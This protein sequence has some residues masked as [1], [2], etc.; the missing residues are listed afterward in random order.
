MIAY[1]LTLHQTAN[2]CRVLLSGELLVR[3]MKTV[4]RNNKQT[5]R[6]K[7]HS[8]NKEGKLALFIGA[9]ISVGCG[10][11]DWQQLMLSVA[12]SKWRT[13]PMLCD[14]VSKENQ[15]ISARY[16]KRKG[17]GKFNVLVSDCLYNNDIQISKELIAIAG[18]GIKKICNFNFDDLIEE[19]FLTEGIEAD[20]ILEGDFYDPLSEKVTI[21]HPHGFIERTGT[22][23]EIKK[24][25]LVLSEDDYNLL[26]SSPYSWANVLQLSLLTNYSVIFVGM[27][28]SDPNIRR[29][30]DVVR[31]NGFSNQ[32]FTIM[33]DPTKGV[34]KEKKSH[35]RRVKK[36]KEWDLKNFRVTPWWVSE[37]S[38]IGGIFKRIR[39]KV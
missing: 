9:G 1:N 3:R 23:D 35:F 37:Y 7:L 24:A 31:K 12:E 14:L 16:A 18:S 22:I 10:L 33:K 32:H 34:P 26:Y 38:D 15:I 8:L 6:Q 13:D 17:K 21:F 29:L 36:M 25:N 19:A 5:L 4:K 39:V 20:V 28:L 27:S 2:R 30:L 11:P